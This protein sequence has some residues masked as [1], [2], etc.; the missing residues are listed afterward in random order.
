MVTSCQQ[1][2]GIVRSN[3]YLFTRHWLTFS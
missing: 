3:E 2:Y 1:Q